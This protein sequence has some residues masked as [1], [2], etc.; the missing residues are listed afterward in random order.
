M[1]TSIVSALSNVAA[2]VK[3]SL[4]GGWHGKT[5]AGDALKQRRMMLTLIRPTLWSSLISLCLPAYLQAEE[6]T[7][8]EKTPQK[9][10]YQRQIASHS[11]EVGAN[12]YEATLGLYMN[13]SDKPIPVVEGKS[14]IGFYRDLLFSSL[15]PRHL[16]ISGSVYP[17]PL[18]GVALRK[19]H[20]IYDAFDFGRFNLIQS[21]TAG[22]EAPFAL[23][24]FVGNVVDYSPD[25]ASHS[26]NRGFMGYQFSAGK[27]HIKRN[28]LID[29]TWYQFEWHIKGGVKASDELLA[30]NLRPG[31]QWHSN[32]DI[33]DVGYLALRRNR[34]DFNAPI[35]SWL[36]NAGFEFKYQFE[37]KTF[38]PVSYELK[39]D[40][41]FPL[42]KFGIALSLGFGIIHTTDRKYQG[43]LTDTE[44]DTIL[45]I[46]PFIEF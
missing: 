10:L 43:S 2:K 28:E 21:V 40:K 37:Q 32:P 1:K 26:I 4:N 22:Y 15:N 9:R 41:K 11:I 36:L 42:K 3:N 18:L 38:K 19:N 46:R 12:A 24:A 35:L 33:A 25:K 44:G 16:I 20:N 39:L 34:I 13:L 6:I 7:Y 29:D 45:A 5:Y 14:E 8:L 30:W 31:V 17:V 23:S 27:Q